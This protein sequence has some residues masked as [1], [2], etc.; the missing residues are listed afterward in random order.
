MDNDNK[1]QK[2][3]S[4]MHCWRCHKKGHPIKVCPKLMDYE[5][6][7]S[8]KNGKKSD[9][10]DC[11]F[12]QGVVVCDNG[13]LRI[14]GTGD[15]KLSSN[16]S[17]DKMPDVLYVPGL[18]TTLLSV[19]LFTDRGINILFTSK[20]YE[21]VDADD[22]VVNGSV[23]GTGSRENGLYLL[24][25]K[26]DTK[27]VFVSNVQDY[28]L[29]H[30]RIGHVGQQKLKFWFS[31]QMMDHF[32]RVLVC[33]QNCSKYTQEQNGVAE[34]Q[35]RS[36][37]EAA[38]SMMFNAQ[39]SKKLWAEAVNTAVY[40]HNKVPQTGANNCIPKERFIGLPVKYSN[41]RV[42]GCD[43]YVHVLKKVR[44][45]KLDARSKSLVFVGKDRGRKG[46]CLFNLEHSV[47]FD[48]GKF[49]ACSEGVT[50]VSDVVYYIVADLVEGNA[51]EEIPVDKEGE[52]RDD[53]YDDFVG[54]N[55]R[56]LGKLMKMC[57]IGGTH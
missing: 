23:L 28:D 43:A 45:D 24:D 22:C 36:T 5:T 29:W 52:F 56:E 57:K 32:L 3:T 30:Q 14:A 27:S 42:F 51:I 55:V 17:I 2:D 7:A 12:D 33:E 20:D 18:S 35:N 39:C 16:N 44:G 53:E 50:D 34:R 4:N 6:P 21:F 11:E 40:V 15:I 38:R 25:G 37:F 10:G 47:K 48:E 13:R 54:E 8:E 1:Q 46:Y 26:P 31:H 49:T 41:L 19:N 9:G